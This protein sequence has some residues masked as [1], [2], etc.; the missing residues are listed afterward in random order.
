MSG[1]QVMNTTAPTLQ[2]D[3][4]LVSAQERVTWREE[5]PRHLLRSM[6]HE[7]GN[8]LAAWKIDEQIRPTIAT[9]HELFSRGVPVSVQALEEYFPPTSFAHWSDY[10]T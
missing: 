9:I 7:N 3:F 8:A 10:A 2:G 4:G 6:R 5:L 1:A